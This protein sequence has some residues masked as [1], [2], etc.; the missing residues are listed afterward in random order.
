MIKRKHIKPLI[1][2]LSTSFSTDELYSISWSADG[3]TGYWG[4]SKF[5]E[6]SGAW[7]KNWYNSISFNNIITSFYEH[8]D[9]Y[10]TYDG[11][12]YYGCLDGYYTGN[13]D[14]GYTW[15]GSCD[16]YYE[17]GWDGYE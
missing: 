8:E 17:Y 11:Y 1:A 14:D 3:L 7:E 15:V 5:K 13:Y 10:N 12:I 9:G 4:M 6:L 16:G 2:S